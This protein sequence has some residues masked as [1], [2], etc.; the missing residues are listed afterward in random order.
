MGITPPE[1]AWTSSGTR[2]PSQVGCGEA[3]DGRGGVRRVRYV[4]TGAARR[5]SARPG[6]GRTTRGMTA[7]STPITKARHTNANTTNS[8]LENRHAL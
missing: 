7:N 3:G 4:E 5:A 6:A 8:S 1:A 2:T